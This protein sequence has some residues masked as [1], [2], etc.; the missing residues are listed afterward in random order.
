[1]IDGYSLRNQWPRAHLK[2]GMKPAN[3]TW[4]IAPRLQ[5]VLD[6]KYHNVQRYPTKRN[7]NQSFWLGLCFLINISPSSSSFQ[8][9]YSIVPPFEATMEG[10]VVL[11]GPSGDWKS[12]TTTGSK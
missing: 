6:T 7:F 1:M 11:A 5:A 2:G 8:E 9:S 12:K 10:C 4:G 3:E